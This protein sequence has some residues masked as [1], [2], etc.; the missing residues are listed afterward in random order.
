MRSM[1]TLPRHWMF[2]TVA[3]AAKLLIFLILYLGDLPVLQWE[4]V[5]QKYDLAV[6]SPSL[7]RRT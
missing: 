3:E 2:E 5:L 4:I 1:Y 6:Y 7:T